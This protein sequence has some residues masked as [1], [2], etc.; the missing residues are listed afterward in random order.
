MDN[1]FPQ[2]KTFAAS[3]AQPLT[4]N[5]RFERLCR[6][7]LICSSSA[8]LLGCGNLARNY[9]PSELMTASVDKSAAPYVTEGERVDLSKVDLSL[10][11]GEAKKVERVRFIATL[12]TLSDKKCEAH[13]ATIMS[14]ANNWNV[15]TGVATILFAGYASIANSATAA[16][17]SAAAAA[18]TTGI[19]GQVNQEVYQGKL[20]TAILRAID[21]ARA[22][23]YARVSQGLEKTDYPTVQ[24]VSDVNRYHAS[25]S[26]MAG[27]TEL[28][29]AIENRKKSRAE[30]EGNI[31]RLTTELGNTRLYDATNLNALRA[32]RQKQVMDL[33]QA[34]D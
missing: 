33:I 3:Q 5:R 12:T 14:N 2:G 28:T 8:L 25:C 27:V 29:N 4:S 30:I 23:T 19:Q 31:A 1:T 6:T 13:K 18:A 32:E 9:V 21:A 16:A 17:N 34:S 24:L 22:K 11:D 10:L 7:L 15:A 20:S 26:L